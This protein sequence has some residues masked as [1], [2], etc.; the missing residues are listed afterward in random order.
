MISRKLR[1]TSA[2]IDGSDVLAVLRGTLRELQ[3]RRDD[4]TQQIVALEKTSAHR[5]DN[6]DISRAEALLDGEPFA[7]SRDRPVSQLAVLHAE[8]DTI[9]QALKIGGSRAHQMEIERAT[10]IWAAHFDQIAAIERRRV[11]LA[12]QLQRT[13]REREKLRETIMKAGGAGYLSTDLVDLLGL[14][15]VEEEVAWAV[16]RVIADKICTRAEIE[17]VKNG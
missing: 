6:P 12:L 4:I 5:T 14:G 8:R 11:T 15:E 17:K 10:E 3:A 1:A 9:D 16:E 2:P 7:V 13:N